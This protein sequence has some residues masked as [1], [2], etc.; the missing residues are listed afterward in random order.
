MSIQFETITP[1][2]GL[3][4]R[5]HR[6]RD[7]LR[8]NWARLL[9]LGSDSEEETSVIAARRAGRRDPVTEISQAVRGKAQALVSHDRPEIP[10]L[11]VQ[12]TA[13]PKITLGRFPIQ[14]NHATAGIVREQD[15]G[16][17]ERLPD[18][19]DPV[20]EPTALHAERLVFLTKI[21]RG[22]TEANAGQLID[23]EEVEREFGR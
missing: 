21:D 8:G 12:G 4:F 19:R 10:A 23:H 15:A 2:A 7:N 14:G 17:L 5:L 9:A 13:M 18:R 11:L 16:F 3:S 20:C 6:W 22:L 1:S